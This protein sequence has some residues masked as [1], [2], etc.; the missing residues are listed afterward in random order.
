[1]CD[2]NNEVF[3]EGKHSLEDMRDSELSNLI[4]NDNHGIIYCYI[5]KVMTPTHIHAVHSVDTQ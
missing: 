3:S 2:G 1:M 4:V 5:P